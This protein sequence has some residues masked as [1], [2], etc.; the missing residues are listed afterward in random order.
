V[1]DHDRDIRFRLP[2][3][4]LNSLDQEKV[5]GAWLNHQDAVRSVMM[6]IPPWGLLAAPVSLVVRDPEH[7]PYCSASTDQQLSLVLNEQWPHED[8]FGTRP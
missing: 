1:D 3:P 7:T 5:P 2:E 8:V 6:Q 4:V